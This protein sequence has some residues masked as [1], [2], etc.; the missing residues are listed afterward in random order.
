MK[1]S[2]AQVAEA[3]LSVALIV[4]SLGGVLGSTACGGPGPDTGDACSTKSG[5]VSNEGWLHYADNTP[6][7]YGHNPPASGPHYVSWARYQRHTTVVPRPNWVHNLE[8]GGIVF[9]YRPDASTDVIASLD[10]LYAKL[11][12]D[13]LCGHTRTLM[14]ED[15]KLLTPVAAVA[16]DYVLDGQCVVE[17]AWLDFVGSRRGNGP[18]QVCADGSFP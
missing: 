1:R 6:V 5:T 10:A 12:V 11:P 15:P 17:R 18:E 2:L 14:T 4:A 7:Q 9:L 16:A 3:L 13:Q 8:H